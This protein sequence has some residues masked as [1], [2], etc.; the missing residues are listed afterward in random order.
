MS[1]FFRASHFFS[2]QYFWNNA[3]GF[4]CSLFIALCFIDFVFPVHFIDGT[5]AYWQAQTQDITQYQAGLA[6]F[7]HEPWQH[8]LLRIN[9]LNWPDGTLAT[10]AD[11]IP[12]YALL[13]KGLSPF[14]PMPINPFGYWVGLCLILQAISAWWILRAARINDGVALICLT[15][16]LLLFPAWLSRMGHISLLSQWLITF[17]IALSIREHQEQNNFPYAWIAL[18][19]ISGLINLYLCAMVCAIAAAQSFYWFTRLGILKSVRII[20]CAVLLA[21][22]IFLVL[23]WPLPPANGAPDGGYSLYSANLLSPLSGNLNNF[24]HFKS[25]SNE[26]AFEGFNYLGAG[27]L[28]I[29]F[30]ASAALFLKPKI[31]QENVVCDAHD[32]TQSARLNTVTITTKTAGFPLSVPLIC[33]LLLMAC[34]SLSNEIYWG[35]KLLY[36]WSIPSS[37]QFVTG[38]FRASGRFFWP[39]GYA[40]LICGVIVLLRKLPRTLAHAILILALCLQIIDLWPQI[41]SLRHIHAPENAQVIDVTQWREAIPR[42]TEHLYFF[43]KMRCATQSDLYKTLLPVM[44]FATNEH[45]TINT[46]YLARYTPTCHEEVREILQSNPQKSVYIFTQQDYSAQQVRELFPQSWNNLCTSLNFAYLCIVSTK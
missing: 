28:L 9:T 21:C 8:P 3:G 34:Y 20:I 42:D 26:Q 1:I 39:L 40:L 18:G 24:F 46:A 4:L 43:P 11:I 31:A 17:A 15:L 45:M 13:L 7:I 19:A 25:A 14:V 23:M 10:F 44:S 5:H 36:T 32:A 41:Q 33:T 22:I 16:L 2:R 37:L 6:A 12:L 27:G 30:L 35:Q 29:L 38:Q